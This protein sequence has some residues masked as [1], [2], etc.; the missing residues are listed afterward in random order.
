M[1]TTDDAAPPALDELTLERLRQS[2]L[3]LDREGRWW[4][5]EEPVAHE[6]LSRAL[7]RWLDRLD[8]GRH[9]V[10]L[11]ERR[12]AYVQVEDAPYVVRT[13]ELEGRGDAL[14]VY[15]RL[16]DGSEEELDYGSLEVGQDNA[17]YCR[18]KAGRD[19]ARF[20]RSA[21]YLL[22]ELFEEAGEQGEEGGFVLR[23]AGRRWPVLERV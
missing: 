16:S 1:T 22:G 21:Y 5:G 17:L 2:G 13:V 7:H 23:A 14:R 20:Q 15:L 6:G 8:D 12:Y 18:V 11:D 3:R 4:H 19:E 10:R 9:I